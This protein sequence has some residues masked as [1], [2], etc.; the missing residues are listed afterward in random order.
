MAAPRAAYPN[1]G[2]IRQHFRGICIALGNT[3]LEVRILSCAPALHAPAV[4][5]WLSGRPLADP[6]PGD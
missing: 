1:A 6:R 3:R 4:A 2:V 5:S